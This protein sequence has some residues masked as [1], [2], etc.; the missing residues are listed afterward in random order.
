MTGPTKQSVH[1]QQHASFRRW[2]ASRGGR[3]TGSCPGQR[4][5]RAPPHLHLGPRGYY[6]CLC[7]GFRNWNGLGGH[8]MLTSGESPESVAPQRAENTD[9]AGRGG[10]SRLN[11]KLPWLG[12]AVGGSIPP[13][14]RASSQPGTHEVRAPAPTVLSQAQGLH[15]G[16]AEPQATKGQPPSVRVWSGRRGTTH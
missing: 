13:R 2:G 14:P 16:G 5:P 9:R 8:G 1:S 12:G 10:S 7:L 11:W 4:A 15:Q 3:P 6:S